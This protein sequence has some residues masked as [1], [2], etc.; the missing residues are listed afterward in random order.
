MWD[1]LEAMTKD[2]SRALTTLK[3]DGGA[4]KNDLLVQFQAD[5]GQVQV[6]RPVEV[7]STGRGAAMLAGVGAD[8]SDL[9]TASRM[10]KVDR[11][12][13]PSIDASARAAHI[14]RWRRAIEQT[15]TQR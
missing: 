9:T 13:D 8:L 6:C 11:T 15:R 3:V 2:A 7:E 5:I 10:V 12:F 4:A 1:L 14:A